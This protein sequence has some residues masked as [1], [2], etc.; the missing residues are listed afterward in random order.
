L[1]YHLGEIKAMTFF[2]MLRVRCSKRSARNLRENNAVTCWAMLR[3][4]YAPIGEE[5]E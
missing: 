2:R 3:V 1:I 5:S 4:H